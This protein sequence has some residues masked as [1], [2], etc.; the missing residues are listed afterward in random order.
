MPGDD[1]S[2]GSLLARGE[3]RWVE[4]SSQAV[5]NERGSPV[6]Y[7]GVATDITERKR[8]EEALRR[9][10]D[11]L[12]ALTARLQT[13]AENERLRI[14]RELHDQVEQALS[15]LKMDLD[16]IVRKHDVDPQLTVPMINDAMKI[17]DSTVGLV[18]RISTDLRPELLDA[19][20]LPAASAW[21]TAEFQRRSGIRCVVRVPEHAM[22]L[23][24]D[25]G[26]AVFRIFQEALANVARHAHAENVMVTLKCEELAATL[27][28]DDDG[29]GFSLTEEE[30]INSLG[31][32]GM[33]ERAH[34]LG[35]D[36][37][38][39]SAPDHGTSVTLRVPLAADTAPLRK[40]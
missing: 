11:E 1:T 4:V 37:S 20:G 18:R 40:P 22:G 6:H 13:I 33:R 8:A 19:L 23:S 31:L 10:E 30:R 3:I 27:V 26:I 35:A 39:Q 7:I 16:W 2:I 34:M 17:I 14:A 25:Q 29:A 9:S 12:R 38:I 36:L 21:H 15:A 32:L 5:R 28:V 24:A